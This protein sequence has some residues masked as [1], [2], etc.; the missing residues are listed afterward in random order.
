MI[1]G[2]LG[3]TKAV[4]GVTM[5]P[6]VFLERMY[7][8]GAH[9][10]FDALSCHP[11]HYTLPFSQGAGV[12]DSPV[13][14]VLALRAL[15]EANGDGDLKLWATEY[16]SPTTPFF[17]VSEEQQAAFMEDFIAAW[18]NIEG[19]GPSVPVLREGREHRG[20][21]QRSQ[22]R[23]VPS[24]L[25]AEEFVAIL[26]EIQEDLDDG[27]L[28]MEFTASKVPFKMFIQLASLVLGVT[29]TALIIPRAIVDGITT[30][31]R[32]VIDAVVTWYGMWCHLRA[33]QQRW[34][35][36]GG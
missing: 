32:Q 36:P 4:S 21:G 10:Y 6:E 26:K 20:V 33:P 31:A 8:V 29:N 3:A 22:L 27:V 25:D 23:F 18:Q 2:V 7:E 16:G 19:A 28:D 11:Y 24:Q 34:S 17:G 13:Q 35:L 5:A 14:Q 9:G 15:M 12:A 30:L 1:G